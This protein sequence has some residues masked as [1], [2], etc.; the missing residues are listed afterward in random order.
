VTIPI[1]SFQSPEHRF[2]SNF[3]LVPGGIILDG[4]RYPTVEHAYQAAKSLDP[5][6]RFHIRKCGPSGTAK[7]MGSPEYM[8]REGYVLRHDW[9]LVKLDLMRDFL[10][11]K[12]RTGTRL[13]QLLTDT[14][15]A[16]LVEGNT[17]GDRFWGVHFGRGE[18]HL[19]RLLME[20]R[21]E[22]WLERA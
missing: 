12:F 16:Q 22:L 10:R 1:T 8:A 20:R 18:N 13:A 4:T 7:R 11:Q 21:G 3:F 2:L 14:G 19:G 17:W 6:H 5:M 9:E 15:D